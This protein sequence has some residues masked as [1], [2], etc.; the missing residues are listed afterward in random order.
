LSRAT[1]A[2]HGQ[3]RIIRPNSFCPDQNCVHGRPK[4]MR[5]AASSSV[6]NPARLAG[7]PRQP[8][9]E[10]HPAFSDNKR[11][12][13]DNPFI[14][15][16]VKPC[17]LFR[18]NALANFD[19]CTSQLCNSVSLVA[20]IQVHGA[21]YYTLH[22]SFNDRVRTRIG[23]ADRRTG[24]QSNIE[25]RVTRHRSSEI[26]QTFNLGVFTACCAMMSFCHYPIVYNQNC[27]HGGIG[28]G[29]PERFFR[30]F[31]RGMH[32]PLV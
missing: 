2:A 29:L 26:A 25:R 3:S 5:L 12:P 21:D 13:G 18:Q 19:P 32:E 15:S 28:T 17:A 10:G 16:L 24:F 30:F 31:E 7:R 23:P 11:S 6:G 1:Y 20:W 14:E 9:I 22:S 27:S 4:L 8:A